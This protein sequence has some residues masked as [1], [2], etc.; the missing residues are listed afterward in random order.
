MP[1]FSLPHILKQRKSES[2]KTKPVKP[3][4]KLNAVDQH[5]LDSWVQA[6]SYMR[7]CVNGVW[8]DLNVKADVKGAVEKESGERKERKTKTA[9]GGYEKLR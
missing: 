9:M 7:E 6:N 4:S 3:K 5:L 8:V 2:N 1:S